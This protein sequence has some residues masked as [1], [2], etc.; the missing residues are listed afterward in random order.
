M[1]KYTAC[2]THSVGTYYN[3]RTRFFVKF[4]GLIYTC[5]CRKRVE[6]ERIFVVLDKGFLCFVIVAFLVQLVDSGC[7]DCHRTVKING[8]LRNFL[9]VYKKVQVIDKFLGTLYCKRRNYDFSLTVNCTP[10]Y[11][12]KVVHCHSGTFV[13]A[14]TVST[15]HKDVVGCL[16]VC[17]RVADYGLVAAAKV[18]RVK[19]AQ[20]VGRC[21][22]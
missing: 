12:F 14:V 16:H 9:F 4:L 13:K 10:D 7:I 17:C 21:T 5:Y 1:I 11:F 3:H 15:F 20:F 8:Y 2:F 18:S 6:S 19:N 22:A